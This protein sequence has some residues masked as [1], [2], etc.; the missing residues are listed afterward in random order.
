MTY[1]NVLYETDGR[2]ATITMNRPDKL[3][4]LSEG[5]IDDIVAAAEEA[6]A[7]REVRSIILKAAGRGL[8]R[9]LRH[10]PRRPRRRLRRPIR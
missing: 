6:E 5:L 9:R 3:N 2:V 7:D 8:L 4:A 10:F 1:E